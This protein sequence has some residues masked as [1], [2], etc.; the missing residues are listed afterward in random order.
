MD[1]VLCFP[2]ASSSLERPWG[3]M[4]EK[5]DILGLAPFQQ[6][7]LFI[8]V[9]FTH[10]S[11]IR[12]KGSLSPAPPHARR[13]RDAALRRDSAEFYRCLRQGVTSNS[14]ALR[15]RD[16]ATR[17]YRPAAYL[18]R[19]AAYFAT[20]AWQSILRLA[21]KDAQRQSDRARAESTQTAGLRP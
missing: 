7:C 4:C 10:C 12:A 6:L 21:Y 9:L 8:T 17:L 18:D 15:K 1:R 11:H 3:E 14:R 20:Y 2:I 19:A 13:T 16:H 5:H